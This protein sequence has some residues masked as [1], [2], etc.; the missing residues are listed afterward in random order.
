[1][2]TGYRPTGGQHKG[3]RAEIYYSHFQ[4]KLG[5]FSGSHIGSVTDLL[6]VIQSG[7][8]LVKK[9]QLGRLGTLGENVFLYR[10]WAVGEQRRVPPNSDF[11]P[12]P[13][14]YALW[15]AQLSGNLVFL[16]KNGWN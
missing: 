2:A 8:P 1:L 14:G 12:P 10:Q 15:N 4:T 6:N 5:I 3:F 9:V 16:I 11:A 7:E 13:S